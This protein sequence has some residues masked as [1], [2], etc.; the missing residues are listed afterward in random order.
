MNSH[1]NEIKFHFVNGIYSHVHDKNE[2][3]IMKFSNKTNDI[4][5]S[6][7][8]VLEQQQQSHTLCLLHKSI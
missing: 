3:K 1:F 4:V 2:F 6:H 5:V 8:F 7:F